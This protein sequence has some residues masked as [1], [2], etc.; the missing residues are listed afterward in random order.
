M[1]IFQPAMLVS[2]RV[3]S[4]MFIEAKFT[5]GGG[6]KPTIE[7]EESSPA[8][9]TGWFLCI[10]CYG[11]SS[12]ETRV[13][14]PQRFTAKKWWR[15]F[16]EEDKIGFELSGDFG[17]EV[18]GGI[19]WWEGT[20]YLKFFQQNIPN[21]AMPTCWSWW[22]QSWAGRDGAPIFHPT[23]K[24]SEQFA[25]AATKVGEKGWKCWKYW[26]HPS[27][28]G[29]DLKLCPGQHG[30][31]RAVGWLRVLWDGLGCETLAPH[32]SHHFRLSLPWEPTRV[33]SL[34]MIFAFAQGGI[35]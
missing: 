33:A 16:G 26:K 5:Q 10:L 8:H 15:F 25:I 23:K 18:P 27:S 22:S 19:R 1:G 35:C 6:I 28:W 2:Q 9:Q 13:R 7:V 11:N 32:A 29:I 17:G 12:F 31:S 4:W 3:A 34:N 24:W 21:W 20:T 30:L 14:S